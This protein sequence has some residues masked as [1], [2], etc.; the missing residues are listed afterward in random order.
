MTVPYHLDL[1][2]FSLEQF[3]HVLETEELLPS[4]RMLQEDIPVRFSILE[5]M[6][7]RNLEDLT[8]A[9]STKKK[10]ARFAQDSGLPEDYLTNLRRQT[11][12]YTPN[13]ISLAKFPAIDPSYV[14]RL[15]A[16]GV[17]QTRQLFEQGQSREGREALAELSGVP[18]QVVFELVKLSD[19][20]RVGWVGPIYARLM[21]EAG[22]QTMAK[23]A[24]ASA[25]E[26]Y[27]NM[28]V[29]NAER[30]YTTASFSAKDVAK[31][32][33]LAQAFPEAYLNQ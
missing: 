14:E 2:Q 32:I 9:L 11:L 31:T 24:T 8:T 30:R 18:V 20:A 26:L 21:Y 5:Q 4:R 15:A 1:T 10:V 3:R 27:K 6:G 23:L 19:L 22:T 33:E 16:I 13:P 12:I 29:V 28:R 17:M 7:I 25:D